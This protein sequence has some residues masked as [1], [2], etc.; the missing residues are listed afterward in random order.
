[1]LIRAGNFQVE[2]VSEVNVMEKSSTSLSLTTDL[3]RTRLTL[4]EFALSHTLEELLRKTL[5]EI[6]ILTQSKIGFFHFV[7]SDQKTLSLQA[8]STRTVENFCK[9]KGRGMHYDIDQAGVWVDAVHQRQPVIHNDYAALPHK[10]GMPP[11]HA[12][13]VREL[14]VPI[15]RADRVAAI[16]GV[17]NKPTDYTEKDVEIVS[18]L[19]DVAWEITEHKRAEEAL[20]YEHEFL[21]NLLNTAQAIIV[22]LDPDGCIISINP[23]LEELSGYR[24]DEIKGQ[25]W[26]SIFI[27][28]SERDKIGDLLMK[29]VG[30]VRTK[31]NVNPIV[32]KDGSE[33]VIEWY[34][35]TLKDK[36]GNIIGLM[37][38][39]Q[40]I[41]ESKKAAEAI[42]EN[43]DFL[44]SLINTIPVPIFYKDR[45]GKYLGF[46]KAFEVF[47]GETRERL[48]GKSVFDINPPE[49]AE[50]YHAKDKKLLEGEEK[51]QRYESQIKNMKGELR[52]VIFNKAVFTDK[53]ESVAGLIGVVIDITEKKKA[54]QEREALILNL[55][56]A[57][58]EVKQ[59]SGLL[60]ICSIC[61]KIRDD[62]GY[63]NQLESY[64]HE[65]SEAE[66]S[67]GICQDCAEKHYP[68]MDL[69][70]DKE[71]HE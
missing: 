70:D 48:I 47:F 29:A 36:S 49:L 32:L 21:Q 60:P 62:K 40:D 30:D 25:K 4:H 50:V 44:N 27:P 10:K 68:D 1:M 58:K 63:W 53:K 6:N 56:K 42:R 15:M 14:V 9:A 37:A 2:I 34:D 3:L 35:R 11:G 51:L 38:I 57:L 64:I 5:D 65:H 46:N 16:L 18:F 55:Q 7:A 39:G 54:E 61:K 19:A 23:F 20:H 69:Y 43:Q 59:L 28:E 45:E 17:G 41:T 33:R 31:A 22:V 12:T 71:P 67:H 13:V 26:V 66:F 8:W 52:Q 24:L